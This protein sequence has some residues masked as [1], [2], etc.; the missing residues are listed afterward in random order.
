MKEKEEVEDQ[1]HWPPTD[2]KNLDHL[3]YLLLLWREI[4]LDSRPV[5]DTPAF[6]LTV[7]EGIV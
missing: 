7:V 6:I 3:T 2:I 4:S 5:A 1:G